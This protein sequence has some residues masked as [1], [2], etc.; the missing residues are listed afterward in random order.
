MKLHRLLQRVI[1]RRTRP[2]R[3]ASHQAHYEAHKEHARSIIL[4]RI[5]Y[6]NTRYGHTYNRVA[7]RN[8]VSRWGSCSTKQNLNFNYRLIFLPPHL[9]DYVI[10]HELCHLKHFNHGTEFW[11]MVGE[12]IPNYEE[13]KRE[14]HA[15][16][17]RMRDPRSLSI[18]TSHTDQI[19]V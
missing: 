17:L 3:R 14:L 11:M 7:I 12:T 13:C 16:A 15:H 6:W 19:P 9:L 18:H 8:Q 10:V 1:R 5:A 2:S 4:P